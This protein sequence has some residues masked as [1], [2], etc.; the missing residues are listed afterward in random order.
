MSIKESIEPPF[1]QVYDKVKLTNKR[2]EV[3][4]N[5]KLNIL[6]TSNNVDTARLMVF[7]HAINA[8]QKKWWDEVTIIIWGSSAKLVAENSSIQEEIKRAQTSG[9]KVSACIACATELNVVDIL[10]DLDLEVISWGKP[11][12]EITQNGDFLLSV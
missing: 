12:T 10:Q 7:M 9:V 5:K 4:M 11:L 6:W 2:N 3:Y 8:I 1:L